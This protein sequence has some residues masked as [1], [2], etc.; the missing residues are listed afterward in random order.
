MSQN[1]TDQH[2]N[3]HLIA[4]RKAKR[5]NLSSH[6]HRIQ[7]KNFWPFFKIFIKNFCKKSKTKIIR[8]FARYKKILRNGLK[9]NFVYLE[10]YRL[11]VK[12]KKKYDRAHRKINGEIITKS[13]NRFAFFIMSMVLIWSIIDARAVYVRQVKDFNK[14]VILQSDIVE[15]AI[16]NSVNNV[17]NYL[18]Y[19]GDKF[20]TPEGVG[21]GFISEL[22]RKSVNTNYIVDNFYSWL[23]INYL[24]QSDQMVI[25]SKRGVLEKAIKLERTYPIEKSKLDPGK[26]IISKMEM[27]HSRFSGEYKAIPIALAVGIETKAEGVLIS[28]II[29]QKI[30]RDVD[31]SL[32]DEDMDFIVLDGEYDIS[33]T[34]E[35]YKDLKID[36]KLRDE[37][38]ANE[39][40]SQVR[41]GGV[42]NFLVKKFSPILKPIKING[43]NFDYY[44]ISNH[45]FIVLAGYS[46]LVRAKAFWNQ[47]QYTVFQLFGILVMF[48]LALGIFK[49]LRIEPIIDELFKRGIAAEAANEAKNQF[50][51]NM[52]HELRTP[53]NGIMG[54]SS[55]LAIGKNLTEEQQEDALII[56]R[57]SEAL[58]TILSD[59]LDFAKIEAGKIDLEHVNF[60]L[61][62]IVED[63]SDLMSADANKKGLEIISYINP[64]IPKIVVGDPA[65]IRQIL[66]NLVNNGIKFTSYGQIFIDIEL[67]KQTRDNVV[68]AF[69]VIDSGVGVEKDKIKNLFRKFVQV[70]MSTTRKFGGTGLGLSICKEL[71]ELMG[72]KISIDSESGK[73]SNFHFS[74]PLGKSFDNGDLTEEEREIAYK[75]RVVRDKK[76]LIVEEIEEY[77]KM[78]GG[79]LR[80]CDMQTYF[81]SFKEDVLS[82]IKN[83]TFDAVLICYHK[84]DQKNIS[85][86]V[87]QIKKDELLKYIPLILLISRKNR[88]CC[89][90][91]FLNQFNQKIIN[92]IKDSKLFKSLIAIFDIQTISSKSHIAVKPIEDAADSIG[93]G[94]K[95]LICEDND[96]NLRVT[97]A[98]LVNMSYE[99]DMATDGQE[100]VNKFIHNHYDAILMDC[101]MPVMDGFIATKTIREMEI[102]EKRIPVPIIALTANAGEIDKQRCFDVGMN[103]FVSKP[104]RRED[105][106]NKI[107]VLIQEKTTKS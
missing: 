57:S 49:K 99:I 94:V 86:L 27:V 42:D 53:M 69:N 66:I 90:E 15:K 95:I 64:E 87:D 34:S 10:K 39:E 7:W 32:Q 12:R 19:L 50:M 52:S 44:R 70:D 35:R 47:F 80:G 30:I 2:S 54:M 67:E 65:R 100:G 9:G 28:E 102:K 6:H 33:F 36:Q 16:S 4:I 89:S 55:N 101:Q 11:A 75:I 21:Y 14:S 5:N 25:T 23:D 29:V 41:I 51:S 104:I 26:V 72:G 61:R 84:D 17:E 62:A 38:L 8:K 20:R 91:D 58:L 97:R 68:I 82:N 24:D 13:Y 1:S 74:I 106:I 56:Y 46:D 93:K 40:L 37:F 78:I 59:I 3:K 88:S 31:K 81:V 79:R 60:D 45:G 83:G 18:N 105:V 48:L 107:A 92:P 98:M 85:D 96:V 43:T 77:K 76:I 22:L 63:L 73:G 71:T 103:G